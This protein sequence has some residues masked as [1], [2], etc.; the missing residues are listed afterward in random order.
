MERVLNLLIVNWHLDC[1]V[2]LSSCEI[3][4]CIACDW[5][6]HRNSSSDFV[7]AYPMDILALTQVVSRTIQINI[8]T[9]SNIASI[10]PI[11]APDQTKLIKLGMCTEPSDNTRFTADTY[12]ST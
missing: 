5:I 3:C 6:H 1:P 9:P 8:T 11:F 7:N 10:P 12:Y 4:Y 2:F